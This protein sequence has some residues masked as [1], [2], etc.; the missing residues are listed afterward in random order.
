MNTHIIFS[1]IYEIMKF[2]IVEY[3]N[4]IITITNRINMIM[5]VMKATVVL[6]Q[7]LEV[8]VWADEATAPVSVLTGSSV[9]GDGDMCFNIY[10]FLLLAGIKWQMV[11][12]SSSCHICIKGHDL[13]QQLN[14]Q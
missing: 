14:C 4:S 8:S 12:F 6:L 1:H 10:L 7:S 5:C 9:K 2:D 3:R 13:G 11:M